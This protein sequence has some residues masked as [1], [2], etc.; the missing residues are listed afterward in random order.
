MVTV[1]WI[2]DSVVSVVEEMGVPLGHDITEVLAGD[3]GC[4][5]VDVDGTS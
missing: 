4:G 2:A 3:G 5:V 1:Q